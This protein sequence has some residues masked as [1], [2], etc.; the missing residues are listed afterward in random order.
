[1]KQLFLCEKFLDGSLSK[2]SQNVALAA[3]LAAALEVSGYPKPGNIH[4]TSDFKDT[5]FEE[6]IAGSIALAPAVKEAFLRGYRVG[7]K[8]KKLR[9]VKVG[10]LILRSLREVKS[11]HRGGNTHLGV[12]LLF[13]PLTAAVGICSSLK[14]ASLLD[15]KEN[16]SQIVSSTTVEDT[17]SVY[18]GIYEVSSTTLGEL[19]N[20]KAPDINKENFKEE[21]MKE[22][23]TL[24]EVMEISSSWDNIS[25]EWVSKMNISFQTGLKTFFKVLNETGSVNTATVHTFLK[26]L[27]SHPDT[28]IARKVGL[29]SGVR[30]IKEA[31]KKGLKT[32]IEVSKR[33]KEILKLGGL[34]TKEGRR[35]IEKLDEELKQKKLNP[36]TTA[37]LTANTIYLAILNGF[38]P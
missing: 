25:R 32:S 22:K 30:D 1:M 26:I 20:V 9:S 18:Q 13:I 5:T 10:E 38:K 7:I 37:D 11:W 14:R 17:I 12:I 16:F 35:E 33:A 27:A 2:V 19:V 28:F 6:F 21:I 8:N 34:K 36:G 4:R 23:L 3:Q 15:L 31:V 29:R 24:Y